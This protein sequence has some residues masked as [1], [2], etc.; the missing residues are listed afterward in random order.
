MRRQ[1]EASPIPIGDSMSSDPLR[2]DF[3]S[4]GVTVAAYRWDPSGEPRAIAQITHGMGE[5][6]LRYAPIAAALNE[7]GFVVYAQD[8]RGHGSTAMS[9]DQLGQVGKVGWSELVKDI[10]RLGQLARGA[11]PSLPLVLIAH[12]MGSFAAQ[13]YL[14]DHSTDV[15]AA[16]LTGTAVLDLLEPALDLDQPLDLAMFNAPFAPAR[17][18]YDWLSR[19]EEQVDLYLADPACGFGLDTEGGRQMFVAARRMADPDEVAAMRKDLPVYIAVGEMDP[20]NGQLALVHALVDRYT[21]AG[22]TDVT[23]KTYPGARHE[24]FNETNRDEVMADLT[25]WLA[26]KV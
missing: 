2:V 26:Q 3:P 6:A 23:L 16:V 11:H 21:S 10:D 14:L 9:P 4:E 5:H 25:D 12:S 13:Q 24:I 7:R 18:D 19:D 1:T 22:L 17:T 15:D 20:V 8:H